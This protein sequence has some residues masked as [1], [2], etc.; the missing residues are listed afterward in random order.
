MYRETTLKTKQRLGRVS[1]GMDAREGQDILI[2]AGKKERGE[3]Q[4]E[5]S[6]VTARWDYNRRD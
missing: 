1:H 2:P 6:L 4:Q 5:V 3:R